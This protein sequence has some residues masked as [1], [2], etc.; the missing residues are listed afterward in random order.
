MKRSCL[1]VRVLPIANGQV[2]HGDQVGRDRGHRLA[3]F[4]GR[5]SLPVMKRLLQSVALAL[6][7]LL[8]AN[9]ALATMS[10]AQ[11]ICAD[12]GSVPNCCLGSGATPMSGMSSD[13]MA[14][15]GA[16]SQASSLSAV[17][18]SSRDSRGCC[19]VS[20]LTAQQLSSPAKFGVSRVLS[21]SLVT[22]LP[23]VAAPVHLP[24]RSGDAIA[25]RAPRTIL[26]HIFRI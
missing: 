23:S 9:P 6:A 14:S 3:P 1:R 11:N 15:T 16:S 17:S 13:A 2:G 12:S 24:G 18:G 8:T 21:F 25:A 4:C 5:Y 19:K 7:V 20:N 22:E 26:F 10:C